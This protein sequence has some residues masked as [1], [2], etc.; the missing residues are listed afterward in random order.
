MEQL[1]LRRAVALADDQFQAPAGQ[2]VERLNNPRTREPDRAGSTFV[3]PVN[4]AIFEVRA[5]MLLSTT[6]GEDEMNGS[7]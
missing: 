1:G 7:S 2:V 4:R 5:A 6:G 3:T